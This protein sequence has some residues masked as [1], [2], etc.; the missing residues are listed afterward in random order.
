[1]LGV[2]CKQPPRGD[3]WAL[4]LWVCAKFVIMVV[5]IF[6]RVLF[7]LTCIRSQATFL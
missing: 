6:I 2:K 1:M 7:N 3:S 5:I 4:G